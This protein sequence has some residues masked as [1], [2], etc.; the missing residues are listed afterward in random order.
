[1]HVSQSYAACVCY[2]K[3]KE[4]AKTGFKMLK[5]GFENIDK[6]VTYTGKG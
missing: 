5:T 1:M 2:Y 3:S 6:L 4:N